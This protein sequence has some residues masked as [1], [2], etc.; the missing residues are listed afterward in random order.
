MGVNAL[1]AYFHYDATY[2]DL[3]VVS[4]SLAERMRGKFV[5]ILETV[6]SDNEILDRTLYNAV[7]DKDGVVPV[8]TYVKPGDVLVAKAT[9]VTALEVDKAINFVKWLRRSPET[10]METPLRVPMFIS[11][12]V[13][14]VKK[15]RLSEGKL[16]VRIWIERNIELTTGDK[17]AGR[18][19]NKGV[20]IVKPD[21]EMP[22]LE[23][24]RVIEA[25][26]SPA[27]VISRMNIGQLLETEISWYLN[28]SGLSDEELS[29]LNSL[30]SPGVK[31]WRGD[32]GKVYIKVPPFSTSSMDWRIIKDFCDVPAKRTIITKEGPIHNVLVGYQ[33]LLRLKHI[34]RDKIGYRSHQGPI[35]LSTR[36]PE[37]GRR[38]GGQRIGDMERWSLMAHGAVDYLRELV[39][40][41]DNPLRSEYSFLIETGQ[42]VKL[43]DFDEVPAYNLLR[44]MQILRTVNIDLETDE[45]ISYLDILKNRIES[46]KAEILGKKEEEEDVEGKVN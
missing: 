14:D 44:L 34:S 16:L 29:E 13:V 40:R 46:K 25:V 2:E 42:E 37:G 1:V 11:G 3:I 32:N 9:R 33:Y 41:S 30:L 6:V 7:L 15:I 28:E 5:K 45:G 20:V 27:S 21:D 10:I 12:R 23:D 35:N 19:G 31:I 39:I 4:S 24:G 43:K 26:I 22:R 17:I 8:G 36:M 38:K 18:H